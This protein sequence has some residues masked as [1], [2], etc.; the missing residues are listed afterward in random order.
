MEVLQQLLN[1]ATWMQNLYHL[2]FISAQE[3]NFVYLEM[4]VALNP[5]SQ[6]S[7]R[8]ATK[9]FRRSHYTSIPLS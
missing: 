8:D 4:T 3:M 6:L 9:S 2:S 1:T 7:Y 5:E